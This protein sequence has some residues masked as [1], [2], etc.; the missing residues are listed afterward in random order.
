METGWGCHPGVR[1]QHWAVVTE[2]ENLPG[3]LWHGCSHRL[4]RT[5]SAELCPKLSDGLLRI[6]L[7]CSNLY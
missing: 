1:S 6:A 3:D 4:N 5:P 2:R 7:V